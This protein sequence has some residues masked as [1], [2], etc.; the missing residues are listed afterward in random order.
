[1]RHLL[2]AAFGSLLPEDELPAARLYQEH[3][4]AIFAYL[5]LRTATPEEA[6]DLLLDVFL[7]AIEQCSMLDDRPSEAQRAWLRG[8]AAHKVADHYRRGQRHREVALEQV[9]E[10]LYSD[11]AC[12]PEGRALKV[13]REEQLRLLLEHLPSVTR[14]IIQLR[15]V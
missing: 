11:E 2:P 12:S 1:M 4:A 8:V 10:T 5:R 3:A 9:A 7:A 6:E 15:F 13:E 14:Q